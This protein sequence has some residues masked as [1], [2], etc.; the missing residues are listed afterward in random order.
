M[1]QHVAERR[2]TEAAHEQSLQETPTAAPTA[3]PQVSPEAR[4][5]FLTQ[6]CALS[7][8]TLR[9]GGQSASGR[10]T[11]AQEKIGQVLASAPGERSSISQALRQSSLYALYQRL[12]QDAI[13]SGQ[14]IDMIIYQRYQQGQ[15]YLLRDEFE[16]VASLIKLVG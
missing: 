13:R 16:A 8:E 1:G 7:I 14:P 2:A 11:Q 10:L 9:Q 5:R 12:G 4:Q 3:T 6:V 15:P